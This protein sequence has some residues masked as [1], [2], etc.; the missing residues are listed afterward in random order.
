MLSRLRRRYWDA[1]ANAQMWRRALASGDDA[2]FRT[3]VLQDHVFRGRSGIQPVTGQARER[4]A[5][6]AWLVHAQDATPDGGVSYGY[7]PVLNSGGWEVSYPEETTGYIMTSLVDYARETGQADLIERARRMALWEAEVQ[8]PSGAVQGG[9]VTTPDKQTA[10]AFNTGMVLDGFVTV[11]ADGDDPAIGKAA[12]SAADFLVGDLSPEGLFQT[13]GAFVSADKVKI[14]NVLCAWALFRYGAL[15]GEASYRS[16]A[17][18]AVEGALKFMM[19]NGWLK[20]NCLTEPRRPLTHTIGYSLQ[21][22]LEVGVL[23]DREDFV[24][25]ARSGFDPLVQHIQP[26]G[27]LAGRFDADWRPA[28]RWSCLT[29]SAQL[30]IVGYRLGDIFGEDRYIRTA[31][32]L[33]DFLKAV[34][35]IGTG[36]PGIDGAI[37]GSL[38]VFGDYMKGGYPELGDQ[39]PAGRPARSGA[40]SGHRMTPGDTASGQDSRTAG[41]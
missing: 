8:M 32:R 19:P 36:N 24:A 21:G 25:A 16:A 5:A 38:P 13:N 23:A 31:H 20:E 11:L 30:A 39:V 12:W 40:P 17:I 33:V 1:S 34:Q 4:A 10:A 9:K 27:F 37:A 29:G 3:V 7:F 35:R 26:N 6:V 15:V 28:V 22:I 14:Y 41:R 18:A 2:A